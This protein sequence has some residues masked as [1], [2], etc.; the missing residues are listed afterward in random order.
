MRAAL[1]AR[2]RAGTKVVPTAF[3][4][5]DPRIALGLAAAAE[6]G[7]DGLATHHDLD[8]DDHDHD[9]FAS[10]VVELGPVA[11]PEGLDAPAPPAWPASTTCC[12]SRASSTLPG[13]PMRHVV[14]AVGPRVDRYYDRPWAIGERRQ[15]RLVVIGSRD[16]DRRAVTAALAG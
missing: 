7:I 1:A 10:F 12:G 13:K 4:A 3:G 8:G 14:Q 11:A 15:T 2:V 9:E 6:G 5:L 16:L